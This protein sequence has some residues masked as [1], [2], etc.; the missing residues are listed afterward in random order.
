MSGQINRGS[1]FGEIIYEYASNVNYKKFLEIGT[2]NGQGSTKCFIDGLLTRNDDYSF[3]S[4]ETCVNFHQIACYHNSDILSD[5][6]NIKLLHGRIIDEQ[7]LINSDIQDYRKVWLN[8]DI[9]NYRSCNNIWN[10]IRKFYDVVLL[11]G[12]EFST[13]AEFMK[14]K[15]YTNIL[16]LDDTREMKNTNV[17]K[18]LKESSDWKNVLSSDDRNG[19]AIYERINPNQ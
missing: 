1:V 16:L 14:L 2:W 4:I 10:D 15:D 19:F 5:H 12:G 7:D 8:D 3:I 17:V 13:F 18:Y 6:R 9:E 11:D